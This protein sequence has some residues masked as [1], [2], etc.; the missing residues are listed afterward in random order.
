M[1]SK[2]VVIVALIAAFTSIAVY[3]ARSKGA[4]YIAILSG[5]KEVPPVQTKATGKVIFGMN[6]DATSIKYT[7]KVSDIKSPTAAHI[8]TGAPGTN[9]PVVTLLFSSANGE[10]P[11]GHVLAKG[12]IT[13]ESLIGPL[14]GKTLADLLDAIKSGNAYVN[15]HTK[16]HPDGEIRGWIMPKPTK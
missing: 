5:G 14:K 8:H 11:K 16:A 15:V 7:I 9:G 12:V 2:A 1:K 13:A 6:P 10:I 4:D 3:A